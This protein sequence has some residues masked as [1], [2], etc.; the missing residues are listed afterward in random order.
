MGYLLL[1]IGTIL[2]AA[3]CVYAISNRVFLDS[4]IGADEVARKHRQLPAAAI[5]RTDHRLLH[6]LLWREWQL[7]YR[8]PIFLFDSFTSIA[9]PVFFF[10]VFSR[11]GAL[12]GLW[13]LLV[14]GSQT[15]GVLMA[16]AVAGMMAL[17]SLYARVASAGISREGK[18][19]YISK[20]IPV[21]YTLQ[22]LSNSFWLLWLFSC[23][24][25]HYLFS[26]CFGA[27]QPC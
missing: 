23:P 25:C 2:M 13:T 16:L 19:F 24:H 22:I 14:G 7:L 1:F 27:G 6:T 11:R 12:Q 3:L 20:M 4:V 8:T 17:V 26:M 21:P 10:I 5:R 15:D 9:M 18:R